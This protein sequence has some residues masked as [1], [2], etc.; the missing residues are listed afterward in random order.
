[1]YPPYFSWFRGS[2][3]VLATVAGLGGLLP[4]TF[5]VENNSTL[6]G[7]DAQQESS[8]PQDDSDR[9]ETAS[10]SGIQTL[11]PVHQP[12]Q[13][14]PSTSL[15]VFNLDRYLPPPILPSMVPRHPGHIDHIPQPPSPA[16]APYTIPPATLSTGNRAGPEGNYLLSSRH[17]RESAVTA[18]GFDLWSTPPYGESLRTSYI[19]SELPADDFARPRY[20]LSD[21]PSNPGPSAGRPSPLGPRTHS[22]HSRY[23]P[24]SVSRSSPVGV[25][26]RHRRIPHPVSDDRGAGSTAGST[27]QNA[28]TAHSHPGTS[29]DD[30]VRHRR[31]RLRREYAFDEYS[32][33]EMLRDDE[34]G[35]ARRLSR[36]RRQEMDRAES[37]LAA[38]ERNLADAMRHFDELRDASRPPPSS[39]ARPPYRQRRDNQPHTRHHTSTSYAEDPRVE[40]SEGE[41]ERDDCAAWEEL[42]QSCRHLRRRALEL[43]EDV[44]SAYPTRCR[45]PGRH[46]PHHGPSGSTTRDGGPVPAGRGRMPRR[47]RSVSVEPVIPPPQG[48][49]EGHAQERRTPP[50]PD[51]LPFAE[52]MSPDDSLD[53]LYTPGPAVHFGGAAADATTAGLSGTSDTREPVPGPSRAG[54]SPSHSGPSPRKRSRSRDSEFEVVDFIPRDED[55]TRSPK[56]K[57]MNV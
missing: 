26:S 41:E 31:T 38:L 7:G 4:G 34:E 28:S 33:P 44:V 49:A 29:N 37:T 8:A 36:L 19:A 12:R 40:L 23:S 56:R 15:G 6:G 25:D 22:H 27:Y 2:S 3:S 52:N 45:I 32:H 17:D 48:F 46:G 35:R 54:P 42:L 10:E 16:R 53:D 13:E 18:L 51:L 21:G 24:Y 39:E 1:M 43:E 50:T 14:P 11:D 57:R 9:S 20:G 47:P 55:D 5:V 30:N